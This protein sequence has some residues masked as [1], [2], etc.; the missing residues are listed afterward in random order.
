MYVALAME[1]GLAVA[2][3][4]ALVGVTPVEVMS[5]RYQGQVHEAQAP[6]W[7]MQ[8]SFVNQGS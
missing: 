2:T 4:A 7:P 8:Q 1:V 5:V 3:T 6:I